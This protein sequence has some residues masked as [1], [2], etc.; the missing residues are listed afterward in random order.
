M[1]SFIQLPSGAPA[2][3]PLIQH[4]FGPESTEDKATR[5]RRL[6][7][8]R[9]NFEHAWHGYKARAWG[10]DE[11]SP[12]SGGS[13]DFFGGLAATLVDSLDALWIIG[14]RDEFNAAA[15]VAA[16]LNFSAQPRMISMSSKLTS[17]TLAACLPRMT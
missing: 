1:F 16:G 11:V 12:L 7:S 3:I 8:V 15:E 5:L 4:Q 13:N 9:E 17:D 2:R 14:L 10:K 6:A